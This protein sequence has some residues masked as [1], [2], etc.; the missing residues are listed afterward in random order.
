MTRSRWLRV[1]VPGSVLSLVGLGLVALLTGGP[2]GGAT[3]REPAIPAA[4]ATPSELDEL[5]P[6]LQDFVE[7]ARGLELKRPVHLQVLEEDAFRRRIQILTRDSLVEG[8]RRLRFLKAFG[9]VPPGTDLVQSQRDANRG[10]VG[11]YDFGSNRLV[12]L[13]AELTPH[14]RSVIVHELTHA[15]QDQHFDL[16]RGRPRRGAAAQGWQGVIEG[17]ARRVEQLYLDSLPPAERQLAD[18]ERAVR[19]SGTAN[20]PAAVSSF[21]AFPYQFGAQFTASL[22]ERE[23]QE[24]LDAAFAAPPRTAEQLMHPDAFLAG[25]AGV[26]VPEPEAAGRVVL[27]D[28]LGE[29]GLRVLLGEGV[30]ADGV[31]RA[32][33]GWGGDRYVI[34]A[35]G[36]RNCARL[37]VVMDTPADA[38]ELIAALQT[39]AAGPGQGATVEGLDPIVLTSCR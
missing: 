32:A 21:V 23:G 6:Q 38:E 3:L 9:L 5:L 31:A 29:F 27:A 35:D 39:W 7:E 13:G 19:S 10:I 2:R 1:L 18:E 34:W 14:V 28:T 20:R 36:A 33:E 17:D 16:A 22:V 24:A 8:N 26:Q 30:A 37:H 4:G 15:V 12:V 25:E 11:I